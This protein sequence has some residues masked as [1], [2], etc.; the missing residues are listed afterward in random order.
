MRHF[1][2]GVLVSLL[3]TLAA[4]AA[5]QRTSEESARQPAAPAPVPGDEAP[6]EGVLR[7]YVWECDDGRTLKVRNLYREN[8]VSVELHEGARKLS[9]VTSASGAKYADA[10][11]SFWSKGGTATFERN[12][13]PAINCTESRAKSLLADA[14]L[15]GVAYRAQGN[16][17]GWLVEAGPGTS[18]TY[19]ADYGQARH[20]F[21]PVARSGDGA[22][23]VVFTG[24]HDGRAIKV[25]LT[26][27]T[28][29]DDMSGAEFDHTAVVEFDG[30]ELRGCAA[31]LQ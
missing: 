10:T 12:G 26:R 16:E 25:T 27:E 23:A 22:R 7:A 18:L 2:R 8:A 20:E 5:C 3:S 1:A 15:R 11:V 17:P 19:V 21:N 13:S 29:A 28:C 31:A 14:K 4:L 30:Q 24:E 9:Q 6:P